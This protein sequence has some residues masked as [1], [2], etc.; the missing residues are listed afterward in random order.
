MESQFLKR[1]QAAEY[2][3]VKR[4]T[5]EAWAT[6][7]GGPAFVKLGRAVRYRISDLEKFIE[8]RIRQNTSKA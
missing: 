8:S 5:L 7:G 2:L 1:Q 4:S 3:N 6:R